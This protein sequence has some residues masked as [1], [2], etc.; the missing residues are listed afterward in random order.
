MHRIGVLAVSV[1]VAA[2]LL[3]G[4]LLL[5]ERQGQQQAAEAREKRKVQLSNTEPGSTT[6]AV[7]NTTR[8]P[9]GHPLIPG[10]RKRAR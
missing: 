9:R 5:S 8:R 6:G 4:G 7:G 2:V 10:G 1:I 3:V